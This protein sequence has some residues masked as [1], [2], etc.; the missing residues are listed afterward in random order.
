MKTT[1]TKNAKCVLTLFGSR[2]SYVTTEFASPYSTEEMISKMNQLRSLRLFEKL[3]N[4]IKEKTGENVSICVADSDQMQD[5]LN[6][7]PGSRYFD[8]MLFVKNESRT[9]IGFLMDNEIAVVKDENSAVFKHGKQLGV[10]ATK[11]NYDKQA[12]D[13][14]FSIVVKVIHSDGIN[15]AD[16]DLMF[17]KLYEDNAVP[18]VIYGNENDII[19]VGL[20][21]VR[22]NENIDENIQFF[23]QNHIKG[24]LSL[25]R[26]EHAFQYM[27]KNFTAWIV[28]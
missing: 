3:V 19:V 27:G 28:K 13:K 26:N 16:M 24:I 20:I 2:A 18:F 4:E 7:K 25:D 9:T 11:I 6:M 8:N 5:V 12:S 17:G 21:G 23:M 10:V 15:K 22:E 14:K 1:N